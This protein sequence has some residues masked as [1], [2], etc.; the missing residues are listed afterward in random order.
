MTNLD[1][2]F[3]FQ[4]KRQADD[5]SNR[6]A[7]VSEQLYQTNFDLEKAL[8]EQFGIQ[9][10]DRFLTILRENNIANDSIPAIKAFLTDMNKMIAS[11]PVLTL[12]IAFE[13]NEQTLKSLSEWFII[14][15]K[16]QVLF[17]ISVDRSLIAGAT[18]SYNGKYLDFSIR[19]KF[20]EIVKS[21]MENKQRN[22][23]SNIQNENSQKTI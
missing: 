8:N 10:K 2:T 20:D 23:N 1:L 17:S 22:G 6:I 13:P 5:F 3:F 4:T 14:N 18:L 21:N 12:T 11:L 9:K 7:A 19:Q 16:K 15:L